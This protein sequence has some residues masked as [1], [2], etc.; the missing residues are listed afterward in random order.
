TRAGWLGVQ[1]ATASEPPA[2]QRRIW[3]VAFWRRH[4]PPLSCD[5]LLNHAPA[6]GSVAAM[7]PLASSPPGLYC[8]LVHTC[9][10]AIMIYKTRPS[11]PS[12]ICWIILVPIR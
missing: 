2:R 5:L 8:L 11:R 9:N 6:A 3:G 7:K 12:F 10:P 4:Q 1:L